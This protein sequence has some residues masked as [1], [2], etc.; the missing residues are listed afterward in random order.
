[1]EKDIEDIF[2]LGSLN[3]AGLKYTN[4]Y[5]SLRVHETR[6]V[7]RNIYSFTENGLH[8]FSEWSVMR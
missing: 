2:A 4:T 5:N 1:M 8:F 3:D 6:G 7:F